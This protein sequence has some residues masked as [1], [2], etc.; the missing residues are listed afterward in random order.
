MNSLKSFFLLTIFLA[1]LI[2]PA[3]GSAYHFSYPKTVN[4]F[5]QPT[6]K[7]DVP[8]HK[9]EH[10]L[11][12]EAAT[13]R[14]SLLA[15]GIDEPEG[16]I[17]SKMP[18]GSMGSDPDLVFVGNI[19]GVQNQTGYGIHWDGLAQVANKF[20]PAESFHRRDLHF[21]IDRLEEGNPVII[22]GSMVRNPG[23]ASWITPEGKYIHAVRGEHTW[24]VTGYVGQRLAPTHIFTLD[25]LRGEKVFQ[26]QEF[27]NLWSHYHN[28]GMF[29]K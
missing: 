5:P 12:C 9:Q 24:V 2:L 23:D 11:S 3:K 8:Y 22:W 19:D 13:L 14:M 27:L 15:R 6:L 4:R 7:L 18:F 26:T 20:L 29:L 28:S 25:P 1:F 21:L 17:I 10:K 16:S